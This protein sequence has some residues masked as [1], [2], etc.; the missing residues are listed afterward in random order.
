MS[1]IRDLID[2]SR[3]TA[4]QYGVIAI[5][6]ILNMLDG[7]DVVVISYTATA[8]AG[9][10][11]IEPSTLGIVFS[12]GLVGMTVGS[13]FLAPWAD[14]MG[15]RKMIMLCISVI[16][17]GVLLT[18]A[19]QNI[20]QL[21]LLRF[22]SG[23]GIGAMLASTVTLA[24]EY[25]PE[26]MRNFVVSVVLTGYPIGATLSGFAAAQIVPDHGWRAMFVAAGVAT[27]AILPFAIVWLGE[28]WEWLIKKQPVNALKRV[29]RALLKM[30]H[31]TL[32]EMPAIT[33]E[34]REIPIAALFKYG[35]A[36]STIRLWIAF[37]CGFT[38]LYF[39]LTW[40][41][42]LV[43]NTGLSTELAIY[44]AA[45]MNLGAVIGNLIIGYISQTVG[46]KRSIVLFYCAA[47]AIMVAFG[48][49]HG[50]A[51][52]MIALGL[53]GFSSQGG[54]VGLYA[55]GARLYPAEARNTGIGWAVGVGRTGAILSPALGGVLV[56]AG[57]TL[58][59]NLVVFAIPLL[60]ACLAVWLIAAREID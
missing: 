41:P 8:V 2:Q 50:N 13:A 37:F 42:N 33:R 46:L 24:S 3:V 44:S 52:I 20:W 27:S 6:V 55:I 23:L 1:N 5:C 15:R 36:G 10:L 58:A 14:V 53:I 16:G 21:V 30:G 38:T 31:D 39:L 12:A 45:V 47:A 32:H 4:T 56:G 28:S 59:N 26:R 9:D 18:A 17:G 29:N 60:A 49:F 35:R 40:I 57:L 34:A 54:L 11:G 22:V 51:A 19:A 43:E 25:A 48:L 7:M